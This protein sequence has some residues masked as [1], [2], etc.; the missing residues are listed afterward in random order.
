MSNTTQISVGTFSYEDKGYEHRV[1][2]QKKGEEH[3]SYL[4]TL[5]ESSSHRWWITE[6]EPS[7]YLDVVSSLR[8]SD[9]ETAASAYYAIV[10]KSQKVIETMPLPENVKRYLEERAENL[11]QEEQKL[12]TEFY[13]IRNERYMLNK[14]ADEN[15]I[16]RVAWRTRSSDAEDAVRSIYDFKV[17][18]E[19]EKQELPFFSESILY[20]LVGKDAARSILVRVEHLCDFVAPNV[21]RE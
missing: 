1:L 11:Q 18:S 12:L 14:F 5:A 6:C 16:E 15:K 21:V 17:Y 20:E 19:T 10:T 2:F 7:D 3:P 4:C 13:R 9:K 8:F